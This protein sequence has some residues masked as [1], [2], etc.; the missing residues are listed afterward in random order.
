MLEFVGVTLDRLC[1]A[2]K[3][4]LSGMLFFGVVL[5]HHNALNKS[6]KFRSTELEHQP[7]CPDLP[8]CVFSIFVPLKKALIGRFF[9]SDSEIMDTIRNWF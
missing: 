2:I 9:S 6:R 5:F 3:A 4:R 1:A 8:K 7:Y